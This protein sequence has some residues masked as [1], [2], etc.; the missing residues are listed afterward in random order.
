[1]TRFIDPERVQITAMRAQQS[2]ETLF[3][4]SPKS[5]LGAKAPGWKGALAEVWQGIDT[6]TTDPKRAELRLPKLEGVS[7]AGARGIDAWE[8]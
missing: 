2:P 4:N 8:R 7:D 1:M 5:V 3:Q 6:F